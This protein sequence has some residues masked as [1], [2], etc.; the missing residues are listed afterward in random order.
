MGKSKK[1]DKK[2]RKRQHSSSNSDSDSASDDGGYDNCSKQTSKSKVYGKSK[3]DMDTPET[4]EYVYDQF[5][6][7]IAQ[8]TQEAYPEPNIEEFG[9]YGRNNS[10]KYSESHS[11]VNRNRAKNVPPVR[12]KVNVSATREVIDLVDDSEETI[13]VSDT[14]GEK[15]SGSNVTNNL[16]YGS[17]YGSG[18]SETRVSGEDYG[19]QGNRG[20]GTNDYHKDQGTYSSENRTSTTDNSPAD[21]MVRQIREGT[22]SKPAPEVGNTRYE[23][24]VRYD[25]DRSSTHSYSSG[26]PNDAST[27]YRNGKAVPENS[28]DYRRGDEVAPPGD[29]E[30]SDG[31]VVEKKP[32]KSDG[33]DRQRDNYQWKPSKSTERRRDASPKQEVNNSEEPASANSASSQES[34]SIEETNKLR[35][36]LGLK[37]LN[38]DS[39]ASGKPEEKAYA[40]RGDVHKPATNIH[41]KK[42]EDK[43]R[44]K[45]EA[46]REKRKINKK[47]KKV[48]GLGEEDDPVLD[49]AAAWVAQSRKSENEKKLAAKRAAE[50]DA[51]DE[52][53]G[54]SKIMSRG[55]L[56]KGKSDEYSSKNLEGLRVEHKGSSL[57][58]GESVILTLKDKEILDE[59]DEDVL[60]N[61][62]IEDNEKAKENLRNKTKRPGY[63]AYDEVDEETGDLKIRTVLDKYDEEIDGKKKESFRLGGGGEA[64]LEGENQMEKVRA[65]LKAQQV[66][67]A[68]A[69]P[70][71]ARDYLT[72]EEM[73]KFKTSKKKK[74]RKIRKRD[75]LKADDLLKMDVDSNKDRGS[76]N[77][78]PSKN[79]A[80]TSMDMDVAP[81]EPDELDY[82]VAVNQHTQ[83]EQEPL[84]DGDE[85]AQELEIALQRSR[86]VKHK[87]E[88]LPGDEDA[89]IERVAKQV[90][91][92]QE[93]KE[94]AESVRNKLKKKS[95]GAIVL[96]STSEFCRTLG[97]LPTLPTKQPEIEE[98]KPDVDD[99]D[100]EEEEPSTS[101]SEIMTVNGWEKVEMSGEVVDV[102]DEEEDDD[103]LEAEP[104]PNGVA[105]TLNLANMKGYLKDGKEK[106]RKFDPLNLPEQKAEV[107]VEKLRD[108]EK[109]KYA[110]GGY[111]RGDR[112]RDRY[113]PYAWKE[114]TN[115]KPDVKLEYVDNK[116]RAMNQKEAFRL[117]SH[118]F[119]GKGS[120]KLKTDK[121]SKKHDDDK[122][123][124]M[125]SSIDTPLNTA[126]MFKDKQKQS[127]SAY[128]V[129]SG[130]GKNLLSGETL[131]K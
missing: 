68:A 21:Y 40:D 106:V 126:K 108:E 62:N 66:S 115:Y 34:L 90:L 111:D 25:A 35:A 105:A 49:S 9:V 71:L 100:I 15:N 70:Q 24:G 107:D 119:H 124:Q 56:K 125:M 98:V 12:S 83:D 109:T 14:Y 36:K 47:L 57:D 39:G 13:Y 129:L 64:D 7:P 88:V 43:M 54:V 127:Q 122:R 104:I 50:L 53:F 81:T 41:E 91:S 84:I 74:V 2:K 72:T 60:Y 45:M 102:A 112:D 99:M 117:L 10:R 87:A 92:K 59:D 3:Y 77:A 82:F 31:E 95:K 97:D 46:I 61:V 20:F 17:N 76:R 44:E 101:T 80:D 58:E 96:D 51:M 4:E 79:G 22:K 6:Q 121:R 116:G 130:G 5:G 1:K 11:L 63:Q 37:P 26:Q 93:V 78:K 19:Q 48:K 42:N 32:T 128:L 55:I 27:H 73:T 38:V 65:I 28:R 120:G 69:E 29:D 23:E 86:R 18:S 30:Y 94:E 113:D 114:K 118:K 110:R 33:Y 123:L 52:E 75:V 131:K 103:V 16:K 89:A 67:L 85:A 8:K